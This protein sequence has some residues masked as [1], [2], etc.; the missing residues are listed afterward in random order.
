MKKRKLGEVLRD[1]GKISPEDLLL[2][3]TEQQG[4]MIHLGELMLQRGLVDKAALT[5]ALEEVSHV[6]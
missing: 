5:A 3:I 1:R 6:P 2:A 4:K